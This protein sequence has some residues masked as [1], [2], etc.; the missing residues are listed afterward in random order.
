LLGS[1]ELWATVDACNPRDQPGT[2]G[3]RGSMPGDGHAKDTMYMR[4][5]VEYFDWTTKRWTPIGSAADSGYLKVGAADVSRQAGRNF[6]FA[7]TP[8]KPAFR[9]RGT[10]LF[11]WRRNTTV[12]A[13]ATRAT[14]AG[15]KPLAGSDPRGYSA[16]TCLMPAP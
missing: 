1:R 8:G 11:Q 10:I 2:I 5:R 16:G 12:I 7:R 15:H 9:L 4:I 13:S 14:T 3:V 6:Q